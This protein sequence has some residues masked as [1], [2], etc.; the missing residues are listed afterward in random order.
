[1]KTIKIKDQTFI[2]EN[3]DIQLS[4]GSHVTLHITIDKTKNNV[5]Y[6]YDIFDKQSIIQNKSERVFDI[7]HSRGRFFGC[8]IKQIDT[9]KDLLQMD[10]I[11]D[12]HDSKTLKQHR[13]EVIDNV[14]NNN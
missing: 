6:I 8:Q 4:L 2:Y 1:M 14:I 13:A 7:F 11:C 5:D 10:I 12:Y 3:C 9:Y